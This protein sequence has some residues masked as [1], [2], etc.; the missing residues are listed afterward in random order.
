[1]PFITTKD[2]T[3]INTD[4]MAGYRACTPR[5]I[6]QTGIRFGNWRDE[7]EPL[8]VSETPEEFDALIVEANAKE[9]RDYHAVVDTMVAEDDERRGAEK[10]AW[11]REY[12]GEDGDDQHE[13]C[14]CDNCGKPMI[15]DTEVGVGTCYECQAKVGEYAQDAPGETDTQQ[16]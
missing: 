3:R 11:A 9:I 16:N 2:G 10:E 13:H 4:L 14:R 5:G 7:E 6:L 15:D 8:W 12:M 1:M